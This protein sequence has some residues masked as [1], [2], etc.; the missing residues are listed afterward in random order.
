MAGLYLHIPF[1]KQ[2]CHYCDFHF[3]VSRRQL[4]E[5]IQA[6]KRELVLRKDELTE[7]IETI[8]WGG[9]TP[10]LLDERAYA[11]LFETL[12]KY[13]KI[14]E[15]PEITLEANP[16]DLD[17]QKIK[18][19]QDL[20]F[21]RL[22]IGV[23]SFHDD[24]LQMMNRVHTAKEAAY[25]VLRAQDAGFQNITIDLIYGMP[26][27]NA[28]KWQY[29]VEKFLQLQI[30]HLS[31]YALTVESKTALEHLIKVG[32]IAAVE[33]QLAFEQFHTLRKLMQQNGYGH[34]ELSNYALPGFQSRHNVSYWKEKPYL[35]FGPSA[36]SFQGTTRSWNV[37]NN[38]QYIKHLEKGELAMEYEQLSPKDRYNEYIMT[39]LRT[40]WGVNLFK[41]EREF[42]MDFKNYFENGVLKYLENKQLLR[43]SSNEII[44]NPEFY[45]SID[46]IVADL[47]WVG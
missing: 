2:K 37:S 5:M 39:G 26:Q 18:L 9:G 24:E 19:L 14:G 35:G 8:Y 22:S 43:I 3:S 15:E 40:K 7:T 21:N 10:S 47:F 28:S 46:G 6:I 13:Y 41:I 45:F 11:E 30:P 12:Y 33:E 20:S 25:A 27:S 23:Q 42:G 44:V 1:C 34:Y 29:N 4:P 32:K 38:A 16:D 31:S 36:H 17:N